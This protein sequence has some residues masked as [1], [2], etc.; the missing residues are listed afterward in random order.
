M[1]QLNDSDM[2][3]RAPSCSECLNK[4][5]SVFGLC[6]VNEL[7]DLDSKKSGQ[8]LK[9]GEVLFQEGATPLG[10]YC[11][12][13]GK[14]VLIKK[15]TEGK[16]QIIRIANPGDPVG[17][18]SLLA[19]TSYSASAVVL[20][21]AI[22]CFVPKDYFND[23]LQRNPLVESKLMKILSLALGEAE[24]RMASMALKPVRER[25]AEAL[26]LLNRVYNP[27]NKCIYFS[28]SRENLGNLVGTAKETAIR[29]LSEFK[30]EKILVTQG[31]K[32]KILD[33]DKLLRISHLHD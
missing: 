14:V 11:L 9:K 2:K 28:V 32:I 22:V 24:A 18:R 30:E 33:Y 1:S 29:L 27:E 10:L 31:S 23:M 17:Y 8:A 12:N 7:D 20:E 3:F 25:L 13:S 6:T 16:E 26:L 19:E 21:D 5:S 15:N 4:N